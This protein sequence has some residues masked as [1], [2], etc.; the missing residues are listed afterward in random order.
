MTHYVPSLRSSARTSPV[1]ASR[2]ANADLGARGFLPCTENPCRAPGFFSGW[3]LRGT[4][5]NLIN[6]N[7]IFN[8]N[9]YGSRAT[10]AHQGRNRR[11]YGVYGGRVAASAFAAPE[12][13]F[14]R[15]HIPQGKRPARGRHVSEPARPGRS[16]FP[17]PRRR[18]ARAM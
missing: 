3:N 1:G 10:V 4:W 2:A 17:D 18:G 12:C 14:A 8:G 6:R 11:R 16:A 13:R 15:G 5:L 9:G 7:D